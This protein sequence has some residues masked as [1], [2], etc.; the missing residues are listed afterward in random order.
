MI[1]LNGVIF[2]WH[3]SPI[4]LAGLLLLCLLYGLAAWRLRRAHP[5]ET[6]L[7]TRR[8]LAFV[9][10]IVLIA[11][12]LLTPLD[13]IARAQFFAA[14]MIQA[15]ALATFC[16]PLLIYACPSW[17]VQPFFRHPVTRPILLVLTQPVV[18]SALFNLNFLVWH[19]P[20][21]FHIALQ[22]GTLY[23]I[24]M[25]SF[26][27][28]SLLNWWPLIGPV[29][30]LHQMT[31]PQ[32]MLYAF[33]DGQPVDIYAFLLVFSGVVLYPYYQVPPQS[34]ITPYADQAVGGAF[35]LL[36]GL[37]DLLVMSPLF[38]RW[39]AQIEARA[40]IAD[41]QRAEEEEELYDEA[42]PPS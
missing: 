12:I 22:N 23:H 4:T 3:W 34:G 33:F 32:Q 14:H 39:L 15:V 11:L 37:V 36:P 31:Y 2:A 9:A 25:L 24:E 8:V 28:T 26:L 38:F 18:A 21:L 13:T 35:L 20:A 7:Q 16:A 42:F 10:A 19:A 17:L 6:P 1:S 5:G 30:D 27:A 40:K 41:Q 29:R